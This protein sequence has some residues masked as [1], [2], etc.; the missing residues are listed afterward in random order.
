M[1][2]ECHCILLLLFIINTPCHMWRR[3]AELKGLETKE[4]VKKTSHGL[5][6]GSEACSESQKQSWVQQCMDEGTVVHN[7]TNGVMYSGNVVYATSE[8]KGCLSITC[9]ECAEEVK[10]I[11]WVRNEEVRRMAGM[12]RERT[13]R[14]DQKELHR[15]R[16]GECMEDQHMAKWWMRP[17]SK[18]RVV[19]R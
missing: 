10:R 14:L 11:G 19:L 18:R 8:K 13:G 5:L 6:S 2:V 7:C 12:E 9:W 4:Q 1:E 16:Q 15:C 3:W 17:D